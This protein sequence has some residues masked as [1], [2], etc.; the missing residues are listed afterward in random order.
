MVSIL[1]L[2]ELPRGFGVVS[3]VAAGCSTAVIGADPGAPADRA[4][5]C[6]TDLVG[7]RIPDEDRYVYRLAVERPGAVPPNRCQCGRQRAGSANIANPL[8]RQ[9]RIDQ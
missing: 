8:V 7:Q 2:I 9:D 4:Q 1:A 5:R 6:A 3:E